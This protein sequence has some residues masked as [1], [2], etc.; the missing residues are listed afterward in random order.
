MAIE[1][2]VMLD[3]STGTMV[4]DSAPPAVD[5]AA[6]NDTNND[7]MTPDGGEG[8]GKP[9]GGSAAKPNKQSELSEKPTGALAKALDHLSEKP[10]QK[11]TEEKPVEKPVSKDPKAAEAKASVPP[12]D[13]AAKKDAAKPLVEP[14][15][16]E[17]RAMPERTRKRFETVLGE[18]KQFKEQAD[19]ITAEYEKAKPDI[20]RGKAFGDI[21]KEY[22][23]GPDLR[24]SDDEDIAGA[25][26][27]QAALARL[28]KGKGTATDRDMVQRQYANLNESLGRLGINGGNKAPAIDQDAF[29][30][31]YEKAENELEFSDLR[32]LIEGLKEK[33]PSQPAAQPQREQ[34]QQPAVQQQQ[35]PHG[36]QDSTPVPNEADDAYY[37]QKAAKAVREDGIQDTKAY[38]EKS[39]FPQILSELKAVNPNANPSEVFRRLSPQAK[40]DIVMSVHQSIRKKAEALK[41]T[42][43]KAAPSQ[44]PNAAGGTLPAWATRSASS[45]SKTAIDHLSGD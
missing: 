13:P 6:E 17:L 16:E 15:A 1:E 27:F 4:E 37:N 40:H 43:K 24:D 42:P 23:L 41:P 25:V 35:Q 44:R 28:A 33:S 29:L 22:G 7:T 5:A 11:G 12:K 39:L 20:E 3:S 18:R 31:A 32:K 45:S 36:R 2:D 38:F 19:K 8:S 9:A 26:I 30:K 14:T 10:K 34:Q 21:V